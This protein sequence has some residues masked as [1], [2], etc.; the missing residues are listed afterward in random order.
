MQRNNTQHDWESVN[1]CFYLVLLLLLLRAFIQRKFA[2][3][4]N[5]LLAHPGCSGPELRDK[6]L[7]TLCCSHKCN[8]VCGPPPFTYER[9]NTDS[10][11]DSIVSADCGSV[12]QIT[13]NFMLLFSMAECSVLVFHCAAAFTIH[14]ESCWSPAAKGCNELQF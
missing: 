8:A 2:R 4:T 7:L 3:A 11:G 5:A 12:W 1:E 6:G 14:E 10:Y 9:V 13:L